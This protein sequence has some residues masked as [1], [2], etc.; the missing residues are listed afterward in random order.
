MNNNE[1]ILFSEMQRFRQGWL[2]VLLI[3]SSI[4]SIVLFAVTMIEEKKPLQEILLFGSII[5]FITLINIAAFYFVRFETQVT[6]HGINYR[7]WPFFQKFSTINWN[8]INQAA[9]RNYPYSKI[10]HHQRKGFGNVHNVEGGKGIQ[11]TLKNGKKIFIGSQK[12]LAFQHSIEK[13]INKTV[14]MLQ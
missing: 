14:A 4:V 9:V 2:W 11:L 8:D 3:K 1:H 10:G 5:F 7:W 6:T 12:I 13:S